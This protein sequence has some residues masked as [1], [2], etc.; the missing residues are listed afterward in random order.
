MNPSSLLLKL[1]ARRLGLSFL[2]FG[3]LAAAPLRAALALAPAFGDG[4]VLQRELPVRIWG[5]A[6]PGATVTV[7]FAGQSVRATTDASGSW[8]ATL[9]PLAASAEGAVL[10]VTSGSERIE[11]RDVLV[12]EVWL[13]SGQSNMQLPA[14]PFLVPSPAGAKPVENSPGDANLKALV[15]AAPYSRVRLV[16]TT[17][18]NN[19]A[20]PRAIV[21]QPAT[22][23]NLLNF[24]AQLQSMGVPLSAKLDVPVGLILVAVGG[25]PSGRW[26]S[27]EALAADPAAAAIAK[28]RAGFDRAAEERKFDEASAAYEAALA[29][30]QKLPADRQKT[31]KQPAKPSP[32][33]APGEGQRWPVGDLRAAVLSPFIGYTLRG[34]YWDQGE[35]GTMVRG[36]DQSVLMPALIA[37]WRADWGQGDFPWIFIPKPSGGGC[38]FDPA[39]PVFGW[40]S[41]PFE[42]LPAQPP[43][44]VPNRVL[45]QNLTSIPNTHLVTTS[46]LGAGLH[47][48]NKFA[49]GTRGLNVIL[50]CVYGRDLP[51]SGPVFRAA[52]V[53]GERIRVSFDHAR[54]GLVH[55]HGDRLQGFAIAGADKKFVWA[56]ARIEGDTV[57]V[58]AAAV[59]APRFVRYAFADS[60]RWANLFNAAGLPAL[61]FRTDP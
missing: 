29:E 12:G 57:L 45:Y 42:A 5:A 13:G 53:E 28:A 26:I 15:D 55:R 4:M 37:S 11:R 47:P 34:V 49:Y 19:S 22:R 10:V 52:A 14:Q 7:A 9:A 23:E 20:P 41:E 32:V 16:C 31:V 60:I 39:D 27:P 25:S 1:H 38:A 58:S 6:A 24:S 59:P 17:F 2:L 30:W 44:K 33:V 43:G 8:R 40:A 48:A 51:S 35:S 21:W 54:G 3:L 56:E 50:A 46:D 61:A 18:N 36:V